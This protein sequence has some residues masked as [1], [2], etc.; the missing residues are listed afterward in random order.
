MVRGGSVRATSRIKVGDK[1]LN[2]EGGPAVIAEVLEVYG[3][4]GHKHAMVRMP[5]HGPSGEVLEEYDISVPVQDLKV[6]EV[7]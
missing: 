5:V 7:A 4:T 6:V 2:P 3:P 1:V